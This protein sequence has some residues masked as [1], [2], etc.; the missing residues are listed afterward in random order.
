[1]K[2]LIYSCIKM[3]SEVSIRIDPRF[4]LED[5]WKLSVEPAIEEA[6]GRGVEVTPLTIFD[7][8]GQIAGW[9]LHGWKSPPPVT[10]YSLDLE[11]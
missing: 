2:S 5:N 8:E 7:D 6:K 1:M 3:A 11:H 10:M 4:S 9:Q